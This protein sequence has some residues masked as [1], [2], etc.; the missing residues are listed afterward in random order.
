MLIYWGLFGFFAFAALVFSKDVAFTPAD[1]PAHQKAA[2]LPMMFVG[3]VLSIIIGLRYGVGGDWGHYVDSY[4]LISRQSLT[5]AI[6]TS[7]SEPAYTALNWVAS[8]VGAGIW[9][10]NL[11]CA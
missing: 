8:Q 6:V 1:A 10:V 5:D 9:L 7:R 11:C 3:I 2:E 4:D